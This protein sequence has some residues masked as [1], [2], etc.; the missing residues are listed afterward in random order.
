V[1]GFAGVGFVAVV[2]LGYYALARHKGD[3]PDTA[4]ACFPLPLFNGRDR[5]E[6]VRF[7]RGPILVRLANFP[8]LHPPPPTS[9]TV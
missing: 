2:A 7:L 6:P 1:G 3:H 8:H 4:A 9:E 5:R